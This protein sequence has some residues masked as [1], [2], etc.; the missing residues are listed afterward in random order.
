MKLAMVITSIGLCFLGCSVKNSNPLINTNSFYFVN[1]P[2]ANDTSALV[3][4]NVLLSQKYTLA[5]DTSAFHIDSSYLDSSFTCNGSQCQWHYNVKYDTVIN[6]A[7]NYNHVDSQRSFRSIKYSFFNDD[8]DSCQAQVMIEDAQGTK[9][10]PDSVWGDVFS[11]PGTD[12]LLS[13]TFHGKYDYSSLNI[14]LT[15]VQINNPKRIA[16]VTI[17]NSWNLKSLGDTDLVVSDSGYFRMISGKWKLVADGYSIYPENNNQPTYS[18]A[19]QNI[20]YIINNDSLN[21]YSNDTLNSS[22]LI[23]SR[24][25]WTGNL[26]KSDWGIASKPYSNMTLIGKDTLLNTETVESDNGNINYL[27]LMVRDTSSLTR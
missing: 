16:T 21:Y 5:V 27:A 15:L 1:T 26:N 14:I 13:F 17:Q 2:A 3:G 4:Y 11:K 9:I 7:I 20:E 18:F 22:Y 8:N 12:R 23:Q 10:Y 24:S 6:L 25:G 19:G